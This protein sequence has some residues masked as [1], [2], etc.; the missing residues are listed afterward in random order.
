MNPI[1]AQIAGH[2]ARGFRVTTQT[3]DSAA[4]V[5]PKSFSFIAFA[6]VMLGGFVL[7][8]FPGLLVG[9]L[10]VAWYMSKRDETVFLYLDEAGT[11]RTASGNQDSGNAR[12]LSLTDKS[13]DELRTQRQ[14][15]LGI[16]CAF[17]VA[18]FLLR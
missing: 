16:G 11:V 17:A 9:L 3:S 14:W 6:L 5:R 18:Y 10:Y 12:A 1:Q 2:V 13:D 8:T 7:F 4:L 15:I